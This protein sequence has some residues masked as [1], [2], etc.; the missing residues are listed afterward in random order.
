MW[1]HPLKCHN[2]TCFRHLREKYK[3]LLIFGTLFVVLMKI[4]L[5]C[6]VLIN[7]N[8]IKDSSSSTQIKDATTNYNHTITKD[9]K[10]INLSRVD[11]ENNNKRRKIGKFIDFNTEIL[12]Q[13]S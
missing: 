2:F 13:S 4:N 3:F 8:P 5:S 12:F 6:A 9:R 1:R 7:E 10:F 11:N